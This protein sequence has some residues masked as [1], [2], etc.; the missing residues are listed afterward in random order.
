[1]LA[2]LAPFISDDPSA[3]HPSIC[4][5]AHWSVL[6]ATPRGPVEAPSQPLVF[7]DLGLCPPHRSRVCNWCF[8]SHT[9]LAFLCGYS[10]G[11]SSF[12][13]RIKGTRCLR[14]VFSKSMKASGPLQIFNLSRTQRTKNSYAV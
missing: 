11:P 10:E 13:W 14:H 12:F 6:A 3:A 9:F 4:L 7:P 1:M 5:T 8:F 2:R